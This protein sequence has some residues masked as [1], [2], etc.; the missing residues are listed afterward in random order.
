MLEI[1]ERSD[2]G[3]DV[4]SPAAPQLPIGLPPRAIEQLKR[5]PGLARLVER[6]QLVWNPTT[7]GFLSP[8]FPPDPSDLRGTDYRP[9]VDERT[10]AKSFDNWP[11][12]PQFQGYDASS[13]VSQQEEEPTHVEI[14]DG[15]QLI[16]RIPWVD[17]DCIA[18]W[19]TPCINGHGGPATPREALH[20]LIWAMVPYSK[21]PELQSRI[22]SRQCYVHNGVPHV[23]LGGTRVA[24]DGK[25][26]PGVLR[27]IDKP[28]RKYL[29]SEILSLNTPAE[30]L[31]SRIAKL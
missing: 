27:Q 25:T 15:D 26:A 24:Y 14:Y 8:N 19:G 7:G 1:R 29:L 5:N 17:V 4:V 10:G 28:L 20:K 30:T 31:E 18:T 2:G 9:R 11:H 22:P 16:I 12:P 6:K 13:I 21:V 23:T 3:I